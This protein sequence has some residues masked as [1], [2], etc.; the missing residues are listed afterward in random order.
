M[1]NQGECRGGGG[2]EGSCVG[3]RGVEEWRGR[4]RGVELR[5][6]KERRLG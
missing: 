6:V 4:G 2:G 5:R 1:R 3:S